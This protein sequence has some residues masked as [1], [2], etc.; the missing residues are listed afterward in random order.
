MFLWT[1]KNIEN[2]FKTKTKNPTPSAAVGAGN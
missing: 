1:N 2:I